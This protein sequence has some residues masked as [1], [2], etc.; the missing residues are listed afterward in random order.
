MEGV[1]RKL[2]FALLASALQGIKDLILQYKHNV[3]A[4]IVLG[5]FCYNV[6]NSSIRSKIRHVS[7][8]QELS[9]A[10]L[11]NYAKHTKLVLRTAQIRSVAELDE[12]RSTEKAPFI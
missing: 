6:E 2:F 5:L 7:N 1:E 12:S 9:N 11:T 4:F 10:V 8:G 3:D